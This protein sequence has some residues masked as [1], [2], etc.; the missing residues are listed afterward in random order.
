MDFKCN[1]CENIYMDEAGRSNH[2]KGKHSKQEETIQV[3]VGAETFKCDLCDSEYIDEN[4]KVNHMKVKHPQEDQ[5]SQVG[6]IPKE[7]KCDVCANIFVD[8]NSMLNH[9]NDKHVK[10]EDTPQGLKTTSTATEQLVNS[11]PKE[12]DEEEND[13]EE[14]E[15]DN[16]EAG[17]NHYT[18]KFWGKNGSKDGYLMTGTSVEY[19]KAVDNL[20]GA[21]KKGAKLH[22][23]GISMYVKNSAMEGPNNIAEI[24]IS[25][26][27]NKGSVKLTC[28][29]KSIKSKDIKLQVN[30]IRGHDKTFVGIFSEKILKKFY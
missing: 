6:R 11:S 23:D 5:T 21:L 16:D 30:N 17:S 3:E 10:H 7:Y 1:L 13:E 25:E 20:Q 14:D 27:K 28:Y 19:Q 15:E 18:D 26:K 22:Y 9:V 24:D 29:P 4:G 8:E 2:M 12:E